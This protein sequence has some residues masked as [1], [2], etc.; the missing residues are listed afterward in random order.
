MGLCYTIN[1]FGSNTQGRDGI[2]P[3]QGGLNIS[4]HREAPNSRAAKYAVKNFYKSDQ[5]SSLQNVKLD[6]LMTCS[7]AEQF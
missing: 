5:P 4:R 1:T 2:A 6:N 3:R 7:Y